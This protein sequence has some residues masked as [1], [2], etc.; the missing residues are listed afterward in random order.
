MEEELDF[1]LLG[2]SSLYGTTDYA[3]LS[4]KLQ[5]SSLYMVKKVISTIREI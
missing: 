2:I 4:T 3:I 1:V 5:A